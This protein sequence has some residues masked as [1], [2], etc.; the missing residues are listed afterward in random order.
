MNGQLCDAMNVG[1]SLSRIGVNKW[2]ESGYEDKIHVCNKLSHV[3]FLGKAFKLISSYA[4]MY[5]KIYFVTF[6]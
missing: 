3:W 6:A 4:N 1:L 2:L 5:V